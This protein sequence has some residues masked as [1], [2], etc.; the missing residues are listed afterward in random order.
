MNLQEIQTLI[1]KADNA[2]YTLGKEVMD[3]SKYDKLKAEL[4]VLNPTDPR[5]QSIG[6]SVRNTILQK[7]KHTI[8][9]GSQEKALNKIE[10]YAWVNANN[11]HNVT[12]HASHKMDGG[13][14]SLEYTDGRLVSGISRGDGLVGEDITANSIKFK[15]LPST[16][17]RP[18]GKVFSGFIR[19]EIILSVDDWQELD[20]NSNP[21]N[22]AVGIA[23]RKDGS[24][25][26]YL[27]FYAFRMFDH[28]GEI[29]NDYEQD[30]SDY[31]V[32]MGFDI[33]PYITGKPDD[34][35]AWYEKVHKERPTLQYWIDGIVV[36]VNDS[37]K[38]NAMGE[39]SNCPKG[40]IAIKFPCEG[41][42]TTLRNVTWQVGATGTIAPV[43][44]FDTVRIGGANVS[45][46][47]LCNMDYIETNDI[48]INDKIFVVKAGDIIPRVMEVQT[49]GIPRITIPKPTEC[50]VCGGKVGHK[51][52]VGGNDS[53]AL[54][55]LNDLCFAV[56]CG[57][58][59]KYA[60]SLDI[61]GIG[62]N[63]IESLVKDLNI[64]SAADLYMLHLIEHEVADM[65]LSGGGRFGEKRAQGIIAE[66]EKK[67]DLTLSD[68]LGSL[69][70]SGLGKRRVVLIQNVIPGFLDTLDD[71]FTN[72]LVT[73]ATALGVPNI[74]TRIN[75]EI[76][77]QKN[78]IV[79]FITNGVVI[80]AALKKNTNPN[81]KTFCITG[82]LSRP[83]EYFY[84]LIEKKGHIGTDTF[85]KTVNYLVAADPNSGSGKLGK[86]S[87]YGIKVIS[88]QDL[89]TLLQS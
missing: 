57:R 31:L 56:I 58:I 19:G 43:A 78:M 15:N 40:Q 22:L 49:K 30:M 1:D 79:K 70:I 39:T 33:A 53:T 10:F 38:Q 46:A 76:I 6:S 81:A 32:K 16:C 3:D 28:D 23:R 44:N 41:E 4:K 63:V 69:G 24:D 48:H 36:K 60:K 2:Y 54:Y 87:K 68:F 61:Q 80:K 82:K 34:V 50:P 37:D 73:S 29:I 75:D 26:E 74:A 9:M 12:L 72:K 5:L 18:N 7:K 66:I 62:R 59:E 13:S 51:N 25:S 52:N 77:S 11:L 47:T 17:I 71:W 55:C 45:N 21:R 86:A 65:V 83:K 27:K 42:V 84:E 85:S 35:W 14:L 67:K 89:L 20:P 64:K 88:E 8:P